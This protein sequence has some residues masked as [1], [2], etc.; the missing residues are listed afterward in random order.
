MRVQLWYRGG[1]IV[2]HPRGAFKQNRM[3]VA[4]MCVYVHACMYLVI[5][6]GGPKLLV[7]QTVPLGIV[8]A[9]VL[10]FICIQL[11]HHFHPPSLSLTPSTFIGKYLFW[12]WV[13]NICKLLFSYH[14]CLFTHS[15]WD[16]KKSGLISEEIAVLSFYSK[17]ILKLRKFNGT[18]VKAF[19]SEGDWCEIPL[20]F[21][22]ETKNF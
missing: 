13:M 1:V 15:L 21:L 12:L 6:T 2:K 8:H 3:N 10:V 16:K 20:D 19:R 7:D 22:K 11:W 18:G 4:G 14:V 5:N 17:Q 9:L